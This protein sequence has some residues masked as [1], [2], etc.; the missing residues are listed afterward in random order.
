MESIKVFFKK[1]WKK[2]LVGL[3]III[4]TVGTLGLY[5]KSKKR[6]GGS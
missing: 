4:L 1:H 2:I 5:K 3:L 6:D